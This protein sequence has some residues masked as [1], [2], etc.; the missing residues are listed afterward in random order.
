MR[1]QVWE[2]YR[3]TAHP[4]IEEIEPYKI[5]EDRFQSKIVGT[6]ISE[7]SKRIIACYSKD[8]AM[9][10]HQLLLQ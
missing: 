10:G 1:Y 6:V 4:L 3:N 8:C 5:A 2:A 7:A 9:L